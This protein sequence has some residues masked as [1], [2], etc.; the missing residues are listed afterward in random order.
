MQRHEGLPFCRRSR[1]LT[2]VVRWS[3][4]GGLRVELLV[5]GMEALRYM[6]LTLCLRAFGFSCGFWRVGKVAWL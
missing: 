6:C 2:V 3:A 4:G 1:E 5:S